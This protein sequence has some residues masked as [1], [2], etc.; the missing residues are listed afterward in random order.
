MGRSRQVLKVDSRPFWGPMLGSPV[1]ETAQREEHDLWVM[2]EAPPPG[3]GVARAGA[4]YP[5]HLPTWCNGSQCEVF[6]WMQYK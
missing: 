5:L 4:F 6:N 1:P 2:S 3:W